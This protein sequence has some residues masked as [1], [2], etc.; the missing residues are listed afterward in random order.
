ML[1]FMPIAFLATEAQVLSE[2]GLREPV[3]TFW[4]MESHRCKKNAEQP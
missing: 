3:A 4:A 2:E 1:L